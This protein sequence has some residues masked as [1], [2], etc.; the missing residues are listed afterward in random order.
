MMALM[1]VGAAM[2]V[3]WMAALAIYMTAEKLGSGRWLTQIGGLALIATG[4][5]LFMI[6]M[7]TG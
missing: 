6:N 3:V 1:F 2:N 7:I 5:G 4:I